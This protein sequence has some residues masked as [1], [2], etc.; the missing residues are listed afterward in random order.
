MFDVNQSLKQLYITITSGT[1]DSTEPVR[2]SIDDL[3]DVF[4]LLF[5]QS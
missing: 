1:L 2:L 3:G 4:N 5:S